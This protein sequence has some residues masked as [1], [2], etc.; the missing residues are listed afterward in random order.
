MS[1]FS[2]ELFLRLACETP[3][4]ST[5]SSPAGHRPDTS[6]PKKP[7][8]RAQAKS[9][10]QARPLLSPALRSPVSSKKRSRKPSFD[11]FVDA[12]AVSIPLSPSPKKSKPN[13][14]IPLSIRTDF[15]ND[16]SLPCSRKPDRPFEY[17]RSDPLWANV[18]NYDPRLHYMTPPP[19]PGG[20]SH[21]PSGPSTTPGG[22][23]TAP[24]PP[25]A[26]PPIH[27]TRAPRPRRTPSANVLPP[28]KDK[29][30]YAAL[31]LNNWKATEA[32]IKN[33]YRKVAVEYHPDKVAEEERETATRMMQNVNAAKEV[34]LDAKRRKA[35]HLSGKLPWTT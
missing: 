33:A 25:P 23:W 2:E 29:T 28:P 17:S 18:E 5:S 10:Q 26:F 14:R 13:S 16:T 1:D 12:A 35:Y 20:A 19:T 8:T 9:E 34:L 31:N 21:I 30:L 4:P 6:F 27:P 32:Q 7:Y 22:P 15:A 24:P 3:L 11:I